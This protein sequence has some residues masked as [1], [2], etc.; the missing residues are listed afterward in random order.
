MARMNRA[1][2]WWSWLPVKRAASASWWEL[3][4]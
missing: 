2:A 3:K 1:M 4:P